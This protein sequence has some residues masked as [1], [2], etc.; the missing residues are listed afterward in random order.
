[1]E[2]HSCFY[3]NIGYFGPYPD[4]STLISLGENA[5]IVDLT[6]P[7]DNLSPYFFSGKTILYPIRDGGTPTDLREFLRLVYQV[8]ELLERGIVVYIHCRGGHGRSGMVA[9]CVL[10]VLCNYTP[11]EAIDSTTRAHQ[12][13]KNLKNKWKKMACP[14]PR[15][16]R[17]WIFKNFSP[18]VFSE[19]RKYFVNNYLGLTSHSRIHIQENVY[20]SAINAYLSLENS[21]DHNTEIMLRILLVKYRLNQESRNFLLNTGGRPFIYRIPH[22]FWGTGEKCGQN[23]V[24]SLVS[25]VRRILR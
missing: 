12:Q 25:K 22:H 5:Y 11:V 16:Q 10:C 23:I 15:N 6:S 7:S 13:R 9:A 2:D 24:G 17:E 4:Q 19:D 14:H 1:M 3:K 21:P 18:I 8:A 20:Q